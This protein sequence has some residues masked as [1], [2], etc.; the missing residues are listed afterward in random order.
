MAFKVWVSMNWILLNQHWLLDFCLKIIHHALDSIPQ[1]MSLLGRFAL[2]MH[3]SPST[4]I[5]MKTNIWNNGFCVDVN[6]YKIE[7][8]HE[9]L[10]SL[11]IINK[12]IRA[13]RQNFL[14]IERMIYDEKSSILRANRNLGAT[15]CYQRLLDCNCAFWKFHSVK[16]QDKSRYTGMILR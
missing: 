6:C 16:N 10:S 2:S 13:C 15:S 9:T 7:T 5:I 4:T 12:L 3:I 8:L 14:K 11:D 1:E